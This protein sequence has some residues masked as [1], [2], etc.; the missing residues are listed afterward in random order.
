MTVMLSSTH[1]CDTGGTTL[2]SGLSCGK[3]GG[4]YLQAA[5]YMAKLHT[6]ANDSPYKHDK[7]MLV[8]Y[9]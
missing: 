1:G 3:W 7:I 8:I 6:E 9:F 4:K 5:W 2:N